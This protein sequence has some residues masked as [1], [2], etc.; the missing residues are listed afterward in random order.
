[1]TIYS[2]IPRFVEGS[3]HHSLI[4]RLIRTDIG[5]EV[6]RIDL[7][8]T[9]F[10]RVSIIDTG[11]A[12]ESAVAEGDTALH[13]LWQEDEEHASITVEGAR[14]PIAPGDT[15]WVPSG[16]AWQ[17]SPNQLAILISMKT[18]T[19]A[20]PIDPVHGED[21]FEGY[22]RETLA[23]SPPGVYLC[24]WK[25]TVPL[26]MDDAPNDRI[27]VSLY[28]DMAVQAAG[29]VAMLHQGHASVVRAG[30][31][32]ITLVPNGLSYILSLEITRSA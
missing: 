13:I 30:S 20:I 17:L 25:I 11:T 21:Q 3:G 14:K 16:D 31:G 23:P 24:R 27:L 19:I 32:P 8:T 29:K 15:C 22:N 10:L 1:M 6:Q 2:P 4:R 9:T 5:E 12:P 28:S 7:I 18:H 26:E